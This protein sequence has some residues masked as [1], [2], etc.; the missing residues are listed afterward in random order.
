MDTQ[1][2]YESDIIPTS[3]GDLSITFL[4]HGSLMLYFGGDTI[5]I[6][7]FGGVADYSILPDADVVLVTHEHRDHLDLQAL[8]EVRTDK[9][10]V[11]L[12]EACA[13]QVQGGTV[14]RNGDVHIVRGVQVEAVPAYNIVHKRGNGEPFHP[15]GRGNGYVMTFGDRR[16]YV[17]GDT[18]NVP[19]M[20]Q[21]WS[22]D[23][24]FLPMNVPYTMTTEMVAEAAKAFRP[25]IVYPYHYGETDPS[26][27]VDL[28][29][30]EAGIEVRIR[31][32]A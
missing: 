3:A 29:K 12:T 32:M 19:E 5:Y 10:E 4:G 2:Q 26:T 30:D 16:V 6:D 22:I 14:M 7:P 24:A 23:C 15:P 25:K 11:V 27:L 28:L 21:L 31:N 17:A 18:E 20:S 9:T 8:A 1:P 13:E